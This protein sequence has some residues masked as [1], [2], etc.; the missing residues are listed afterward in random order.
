VLAGCSKGANRPGIYIQVII[1]CPNCPFMLQGKCLLLQYLSLH[2]PDG[3][4][5]KPLALR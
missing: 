2:H 4:K 1:L 3:R 5:L